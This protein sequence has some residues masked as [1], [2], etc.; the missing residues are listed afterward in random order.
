MTPNTTPRRAFL[1]MG[2]IM[3]GILCS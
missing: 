3:R 1:V 2:P